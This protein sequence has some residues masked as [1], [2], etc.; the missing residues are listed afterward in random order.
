G[1]SLVRAP[2]RVLQR[3]TLLPELAARA[4]RAV[5]DPALLG[6][7]TLLL[8]P[9]QAGLARAATAKRL[10]QRD[11]RG[12][13]GQRDPRPGIQPHGH[14]DRAVPPRRCRQLPGADDGDATPRD[15]LARCRPDRDGGRARRARLRDVGAL[16]RADLARWLARLRCVPQPA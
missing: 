12:S 10:D 14:R 5:R 6:N 11:R 7:G 1:R 16:T 9:D 4:R 13:F 3:S 2:D 15:L 8:A